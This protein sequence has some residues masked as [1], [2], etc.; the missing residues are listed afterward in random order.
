MSAAAARQRAAWQR[1]Y[2][3]RNKAGLM[4]LRV[5]IDDVAVPEALAEAGFLDPKKLDD[6][7][8]VAAA[9]EDLLRKLSTEGRSA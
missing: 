9:I 8:A 1:A 4:V 7:A 6:R 2:R 5:A 3:Q